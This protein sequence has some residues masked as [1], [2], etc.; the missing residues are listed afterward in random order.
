MCGQHL[1]GE[2]GIGRRHPRE[3]LLDS[4]ECPPEVCNYEF[5][6]VRLAVFSSSYLG[7]GTEVNSWV[8]QGYVLLDKN[9]GEGNKG[10]EGVDGIHVA[11]G[12]KGR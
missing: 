8:G 11:Q 7:T 9:T 2:G 10:V 3:D 1:T 5:R 12:G 6:R 4:A